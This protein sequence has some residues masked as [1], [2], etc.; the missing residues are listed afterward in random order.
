[1]QYNI[2]HPN[3]HKQTASLTNIIWYHLHFLSQFRQID[4][5]YPNNLSTSPY[6]TTTT[7][8]TITTTTTATT[9]TTTKANLRGN[10]TYTRCLPSKNNTTANINPRKILSLR[11]DSWACLVPSPV[12]LS[13]CWRQYRVVKGLWVRLQAG[14][15]LSP[16]PWNSKGRDVGDEN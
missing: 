9:T 15:V 16:P 6:N 4:I 10:I 7:T 1:M 11:H 5:P 3:K 2:T 13:R 8:T 12:Y 14:T